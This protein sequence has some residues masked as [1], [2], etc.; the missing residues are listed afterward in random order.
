MRDAGHILGEGMEYGH[1]H[2]PHTH[3]ETDM[4]LK[5]DPERLRVGG[6]CRQSHRWEDVCRLG[7]KFTTP[8]ERRREPG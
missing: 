6:T 3:S 7:A 5:Y 1:I 8:L 4:K 2:K